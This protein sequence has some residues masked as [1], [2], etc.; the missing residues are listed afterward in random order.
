MCINPNYQI[1]RVSCSLILSTSTRCNLASRLHRFNLYAI[2]QEGLSSH[3]DRS[4]DKA[5]YLDRYCL[6]KQYE[7][8]DHRAIPLM[9]GK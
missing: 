7:T 5:G 9:Q 3:K 8:I 6:V 2:L 1:R 4:A